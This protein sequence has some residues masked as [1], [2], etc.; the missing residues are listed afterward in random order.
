[1]K[2][3]LGLFVIT[4]G[5]TFSAYAQNYTKN[6][7]ELQVNDALMKVEFVK[8]DI[9]RVRYTHDNKV[10]NVSNEICVERESPIFKIRHRESN[11]A[12][13]L[14]S[15]SLEVTINKLSGMISYYDKKGI[16]YHVDAGNSSEETHKQV[17]KILGE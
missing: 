16:V 1:M 10:I 2:R 13:I 7:V 5:F 9:I 11:D 4:L 6:G 17:V 12:I 3:I 14:R 15:D 8:N